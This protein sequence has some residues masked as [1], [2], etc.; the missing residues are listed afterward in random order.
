MTPGVH[1][2]DEKMRG[3]KLGLEALKDGNLYERLQYFYIT[4]FKK[5]V[6][7]RWLKELVFSKPVE[8]VM[9]L[10]AGAVCFF[11]L[12][13]ALPILYWKTKKEQEEYER[14]YRNKD[15]GWHSDP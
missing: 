4:K 2:G 13:V 10:I 5:F 6:L 7:I 8:M 14:Q 9:L 3:L 1:D 11:I 15:N 12:C